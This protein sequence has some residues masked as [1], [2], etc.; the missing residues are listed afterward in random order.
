M[1][2]QELIEA[3]SRLL[4]SG[5]VDNSFVLPVLRELSEAGA[6][7]RVSL[8]EVLALLEARQGPSAESLAAHLRSRRRLEASRCHQRRKAG[9]QDLGDFQD[10]LGDLPLQVPLGWRTTA[11]ALEAQKGGTAADSDPLG[12]VEILETLPDAVPLRSALAALRR[13]LEDARARRVEQAKDALSGTLQ[14]FPLDLD[15][16]TAAALVLEAY[17]AAVTAPQKSRLLDIACAWP[18]SA[19]APVI[20]RLGDDPALRERAVL[21]LILRFNESPVGEWSDW[22]RWLSRV[23]EKDAAAA[24]FHEDWRR[25]H[26][27]QSL[28]QWAKRRPDVPPEAT[29]ALEAWCLEHGGTLSAPPAAPPAATIVPPQASTPAKP[30]SGAIRP[31]PRPEPAPPV[32]TPA[33]KP[34][35][36][37]PPEPVGPSLWDEHVLPF[38]SGNWPMLTGIAMVVVG[39]SLLAFYTWDKHWFVRYTVLPA[40]LA[41][42]TVILAKA[43]AWIER[44]SA[45][46][47]GTADMLRGAAVALLPAN[48]MAVALLAHDA[49]VPHKQLIFPLVSALYLAGFGGGLRSWCAGVHEALRDV[50]AGTLL[51]LNALVL[52][53]PLAQV[54][55]PGGQNVWF[56]LGLGFHAGFVLAA[57]AIQRFVRT[58]L[59]APMILEGRVPWFFGIALT[60]TYGQVFL[61]VYGFMRHLPLVHTYACMVIAAGGLILFAEQNSRPAEAKD[62][63]YGKASFLGY[64]LLLLGL[65][66]GASQPQIRL[67]TLV[68]AGAVWLAEAKFRK[69]VL[70]AWIAMTL[71]VLGGGSLGTWDFFPRPWI[72][73]LGLGVAVLIGAAAP[74]ARRWWDELGGVSARLQAAVLAFTT[75]LT[76][77]VQW[78][79]NSPPLRTGGMLLAAAGLFA[80]RAREDGRLE[81]VHTVMAILAIALP[82][83][84]FADMSGRTLHGN[85]LVFG[86]SVLSLAWIAA[87]SAWGSPLLLGA[88]STV[89]LI[90]GALAL[91]AMCLRVAFEQGRPESALPMHVAMSLGGPVLMTIA[92]MFAAHFSRS[93][94][95]NVIASMIVFVLFPRLK[96]E[97]QRWLPFVHFGSGLASSAWS[98]GLM[99]ACFRLRA[100]LSEK[101][102]GGDLFAGRHAFPLEQRDYKLWTWPLMVSAVFLAL[103]VDVWIVGT[104]LATGIHLKTGVALSVTGLA[105]TLLAVYRREDA[106]AGLLVH[107]GWLCGLAGLAF[108]YYDRAP[109]PRWYDAALLCA[110]SMNALYAFYRYGVEPGR[111]WAGALLA[112]PVRGVLRVGVLLLSIATIL[113]LW[114]GE[115]AAQLL[116]LLGFLAAELVWFALA[117][118]EAAFGGTLFFLGWAA[119]LA[120][121]APGAAPLLVRVSLRL[122]ALPTLIFFL[123]IQA[124]HLGLEPLEDAYGRVKALLAPFMFLATLATFGL[125]LFGMT[126][127]LLGRALGLRDQLLLLVLVAATARAQA[128]GYLALLAAILAYLDL[129]FVPLS[130]LASE[131]ARVSY[132][133]LPWRLS[134]CSLALAGAATLGDFLSGLSPRLLEGRF[135][136]TVFRA[137]AAGLIRTACVLAASFAVARHGTEGPLRRSE[138]QLVSPYLSAAAVAWVGVSM[139]ETALCALATLF[140]AAGNV[141]AVRLY[142][143]DF[144]RARGMLENHLLCLGGVATLL[145][146]SLGSLLAERAVVVVF[147]H[148]VCLAIAGVVL[149]TLGATYF[150]SP[151]IEAM[152]NT[153][154]IVSGLMSYLAGL[155]FQRAARRP[156][157][158]E[159]PYTAYWEGVYHCALTAAIWSAA[160]LI[161]WFRNPYAA[162]PALCLPVLYFYLRAEWSPREDAAAVARYRDSAAALSFFLL[163]LFAFRGAFQAVMFP[164]APLGFDHY[165][166]NAP[167]VMV[168][169]LVML[170]LH[171]LGGTPWLA[172]YGGLAMTVGSFLSL[173]RVPDLSPI[174]HPMASAW[175][176]VALGHFWMLVSTQPSP[177]KAFLQRV[178]NIGEEQWLALRHSWGNFL[179]F[180]TQGVLAWGLL[181]FS[182]D[183]YMVAPLLLGGASLLIHQGLIRG[184]APLFV[185]AAI[186]AMAALHADFLVP[187]WL[188]RRY[189]VSAVLAIWSSLLLGSE[190]GLAGLGVEAMGL[191]AVSLGAVAFG[192]VLYHHPDSLIGLWIVAQGAVLAALTPRDSRKAAGQAE[193]FFSTFLLAVPAWLVYFSQCREPAP[194]PA[195]AVTL[196]CLAT[197]GAAR[198]VQDRA[199]LFS[200]P[201]VRQARLIDQL[202]STLSAH[203]YALN[204]AALYA[205]FALTAHAQVLHYGAAFETRELA[206]ML[207][208]YGASAAA[209]Y[210]EG[211]LR[212][213]ATPYFLMQLCVLGFFAV[214]RRQFMLTYNFWNYEYDVWASLAVSFALAGAKQLLP[215]EPREQRIPLLGTLLTM[216]VVSMVWV[217]LHHLGTN[218]VL[219]VVGLYSLMFAYMGKDDEESPY[220][221]VA[222][223]GFVAFVMIVFWTKLELRVIQ[224]YVLPAGLGILVLV[225]MFRN[226]IPPLV[227][228]EIRAVTLLAMLGSSGYYVLV[229]DRYPIAFHMTMLVLSVVLMAAG[230][231][232]RIR[233]YVLLGVAGMAVDLAT[234]VYKVLVHMERS[235]RM[236]IIG[237]QVLLFGALLIGGAIYYK[238]HQDE[239]NA[240][241][242]RWRERLSVWE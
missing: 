114:V 79:F 76:V 17:V 202:A 156:D 42:F 96:D 37:S 9:G 103:K 184:S 213:S 153:R 157:P 210:Y 179:L 237:S 163:V 169:A 64:A 94:L 229:D 135:A 4:T 118:R 62:A 28:L 53:G 100:A 68:F 196:A 13:P 40:L 104:H 19:M 159:A 218:T 35:P 175:C 221:L 31:K 212:K 195:L 56:L 224:A 105:W 22:S 145:Q 160:L 91:S 88:R 129:C 55:D 131:G 32:S 144:I 194:W 25:A 81:Y 14:P 52:L 241:F 235:A 5:R 155:Y 72:P 132:L 73:A 92:L 6:A 133:T 99:L 11:G 47:K 222:V 149:A 80:W 228:N 98:A 120:W 233:L 170:R 207:A 142:L 116:P 187:S 168:L 126:D 60:S 146:F 231:F 112:S 1:R 115:D 137:S 201:S 189:V 225:Q 164:G 51:A 203:G 41:S 117:D 75:V 127:S 125:A 158:G 82:Y 147:I 166:F 165:H 20:R 197:G 240:A 230:S 46:L 95:P 67:A 26:A 219:L 66:M 36:V 106:S 61:W 148:R 167:F 63:E 183:T 227:R 220:H 188:P 217:L 27:A 85:Q 208:L 2:D 38:V 191:A 199:A 214:L 102:V 57:L 177:I 65:L 161:P 54:F 232:L 215:L 49:Q 109:N 3:L 69:D 108:G 48:F 176:A 242:D 128:S 192:H 186:E 226:K 140:L 29:Q 134:A 30:P 234:I 18:S 121:T 205:V 90:Y 190:L 172:Y 7:P 39:S 200:M 223:G 97:I 45:A 150:T 58:K 50:L 77:L 185:L 44:R 138:F 152:T 84:G 23:E 33:V 71:L 123:A 78:H 171:G 34:A 173:T 198:W 236:S 43:G 86:L 101:L 162:F 206:A 181:D 141:H 178:G 15:D 154:F 111:P 110:V 151:N 122:S 16:K 193:S 124:A 74:L 10:V 59:S 12:L 239:F 113:A 107:L 70:H 174:D 87:S 209:W 24:S 21:L 204:T 139:G 182:S 8:P 180:A 216:P 143:G 119:L 130:A 93:L 136:Q 238:T 211:R 83:L 89:L